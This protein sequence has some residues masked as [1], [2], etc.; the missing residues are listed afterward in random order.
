M[1]SPHDQSYPC[2]QQL[3]VQFIRDQPDASLRLALARFV[4]FWMPAPIGIS[5]PLSTILVISW[6]FV[7]PLAVTFVRGW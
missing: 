6:L 3:A 5:T 2:S 7:F 4:E 1:N